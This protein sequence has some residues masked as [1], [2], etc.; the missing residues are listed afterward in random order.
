MAFRVDTEEPLYFLAWTTTPWTLPSNLGLCVHPDF[1]YIKV[2]DLNR[3]KGKQF[4]LL[5]KK[6]EDLYGKDYKTNNKWKKLGEVKGSELVGIKYRPLF[7]YFVEKVRLFFNLLP[8]F[9]FEKLINN[10]HSLGIE[11]LE[12]LVILTS[13]RKRGTGIV[14]QAPAF[15]DEDHRIAIREGLVEFNEMPPC[16]VDETGKYTKEVTD[17]EGVYVKVCL[18]VS[19]FTG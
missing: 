10:S 9:P 1:T 3:H 15:G 18:D 5:E 12:S 7:P 14:H 16:P 4:I 13:P 6:L 19:S 11:L 8:Y 17:F 2:E